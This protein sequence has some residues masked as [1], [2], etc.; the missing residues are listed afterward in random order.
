MSDVFL[1]NLSNGQQHPY[2]ITH[3]KRAKFIRIK[4]S[5]QGKL[6]VTL[7]SFSK[8]Q[9]AHE[10]LQSKLAWIEKN[11]QKINYQEA[12][13][14][15]KI[16]DLRLLDEYWNVE[17]K[18]IDSSISS[19]INLGLVEHADRNIELL[20]NN[21]QL[22][23]STIIA[24]LLN[25]WCRKKAKITF[26]AML[27]EL[28]EL[29]GFHYQRLSI[30]A[31]KTRWGSCTYQKNIN[32]NCKLLFMPEAVVRYVMIHELCHTI[33]MNH[34][35]KFWALVKECDPNYKDHKQQLKILG[36]EIVI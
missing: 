10:F 34:S 2:Q 18:E 33:E 15:P 19:S 27:Q 28:A 12:T 23:D 26:N 30:R 3:S 6:S 20:G 17:Y 1:L 14:P 9:L 24:K 36:R 8:H 5:Q 25:N 22:N 4:L 35:S 32:L 31:Q 7:P 16:L 11:L 21:H 29:H 13:L